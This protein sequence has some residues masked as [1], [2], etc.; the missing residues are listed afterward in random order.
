MK[1]DRT[2]RFDSLY[3]KLPAD[4]QKRVDKQLVLLL[5]NP[6]HPSL[7][8]H[9]MHGYTNWWEISVTTRYRIMFQIIGNEYVLHKVGPHNILHKP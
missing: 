4:I 7:R 8:F 5:K 6:R 1:I 2:K 3:R 9:K